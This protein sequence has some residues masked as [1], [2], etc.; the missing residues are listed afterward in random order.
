MTCAGLR[1]R[2]RAVRTASAKRPSRAQGRRPARS[3]SPVMPTRRWSTPTGRA[4][5]SGSLIRRATS[6]SVPLSWTHVAPACAMSRRRSRSSPSDVA[7]VQ[8]RGEPMKS[9]RPRPVL[10][11]TSVSARCSPRMPGTDV[12]HG[13]ARELVCQRSRLSRHAGNAFRGGGP[14][15]NRVDLRVRATRV[16]GVGEDPTRPVRGRRRPAISAESPGRS[17]STKADA[18]CCSSP[19]DIAVENERSCPRGRP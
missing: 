11:Q 8:T 6:R 17:C 19:A 16:T 10:P 18:A 2:R 3:A 13:T 14:G 9:G 15:A 1:N 12:P 4:P 7:A 5:A